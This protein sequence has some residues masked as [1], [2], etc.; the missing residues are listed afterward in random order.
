MNRDLYKFDYHP[1]DKL[2]K[3]LRGRK[4]TFAPRGFSIAGASAAVAPAIPMPSD[5]FS[6][7][8]YR[9]KLSRLAFLANAL[10]TSSG[11]LA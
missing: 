9:T 4:D 1:T 7:V 6:N 11:T 3:L 10:S 5:A 8:G 2:G